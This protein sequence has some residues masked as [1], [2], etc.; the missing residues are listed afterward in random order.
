VT[1]VPEG[2]SSRSRYH[3][4]TLSSFTSLTLHPHPL[5]AFSVRLPS[6]MADYLRPPPKPP[7]LPAAL[8]QLASALPNPPISPIPLP[9]PALDLLAS[10]SRLT[11]PQP[12]APG[13]E[14]TVSLLAKSNE[15]IAKSLSTAQAD[16]SGTFGLEETW[17]GTSPPALVGSIGRLRCEVV[18][19]IPLRDVCGGCEL[20]NVDDAKMG[21]HPGSELFI[22]RVLSVE[23]GEKEGGEPMVYWR[24]K[25]V[26][27]TD[28]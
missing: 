12:S 4:T 22:C 21:S 23:D 10:I 27:L 3:G 25:Y 19:S 16:Q 5:V 7:Q 18:T 15:S 17:D 14:L 13:P 20:D 11:S 6:R 24:H 2:S 28:D 9:R 8:Q 26:G 1:R